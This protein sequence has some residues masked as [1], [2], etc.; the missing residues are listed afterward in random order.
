MP[1]SLSFPGEGSCGV[2][3][4]R[5]TLARRKRAGPDTKGPRIKNQPLGGV[6]TPY[7]YNELGVLGMQ[8]SMHHRAVRIRGSISD[9]PSRSIQ[10][11]LVIKDIKR[12]G[13]DRYRANTLARETQGGR[14]KTATQTFSRRKRMKHPNLHSGTVT[15]Q[16]TLFRE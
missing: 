14:K 6:C 10:P 1:Y 5:G 2:N 15:L 3:P 11:S 4:E 12:H 16:N 8:N 9:S 13:A 7:I